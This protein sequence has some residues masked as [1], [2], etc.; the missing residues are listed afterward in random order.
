MSGLRPREIRIL[1]VSSKLILSSIDMVAVKE[2]LQSEARVK[3]QR[4]SDEVVVVGQAAGT[5][6][7][8][9]SAPLFACVL[10]APIKCAIEIAI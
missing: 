4:V 1:L 10:I 3:S 9:D 7:R 5:R 8:S 2:G 6:S